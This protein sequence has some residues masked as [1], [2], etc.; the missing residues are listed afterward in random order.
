M[1]LLEKFVIQVPE[2][3]ACSSGSAILGG[4]GNKGSVF[5]LLSSW[6]PIAGPNIY[7]CYL[8]NLPYQVIQ[9]GQGVAALIVCA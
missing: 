5:A 7:L 2:E 9:D 3:Q 6:L 4:L 8:A 1:E